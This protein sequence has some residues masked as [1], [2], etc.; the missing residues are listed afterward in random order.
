MVFVLL[1]AVLLPLTT[2]G[3]GWSGWDPITAA[4]AAAGGA[5][6][7][8]LGLKASVAGNVI[9]LPSRSLV[10]DPQCTAV[11]LLAVYVALVFAY[12]VRWGMRLL[13]IAVG[14]PVLLA[15]NIMRLVG[16]AWA[17]ELLAG[18]SFYVVHD[19]LFEFGMVF[20]VLMMWAVWLSLARRT[21]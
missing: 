12:P 21:A 3:A 11:T 18:R 7:R 10:I 8:M 20:V 5:G 19:Y 13:A 4:V 16:V 2:L 9:H 6:A 17:S 1:L 15:V 14:V